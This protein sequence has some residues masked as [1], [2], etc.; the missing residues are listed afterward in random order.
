MA[1]GTIGVAHPVVSK[2]IDK[3][4][5]IVFAEIDIDALANVGAERIKYVEP[6]RFPGMEQDLTFMAETYAPIARAI[7]N[8]RSELINK[9]A[10]IGTYT[11]ENGKSITVRIFFSHPERTLT[12]EEVQAVVDGIVAELEAQNI[13]IKK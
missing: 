7:E 6:S 5:A 12:R 13:V 2:K 9:V 11:D 1:L 3:K 10:V 4:A 8:A